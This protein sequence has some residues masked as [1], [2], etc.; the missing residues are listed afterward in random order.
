MKFEAGDRVTVPSFTGTVIDLAS[1]I[2][3]FLSVTAVP[4]N[5]KPEDYTWVL[6]DEDGLVY[7]L[8]D[9]CGDLMTRADPRFWDSLKKEDRWLDNDG[10]VWRYMFVELGGK[11]V[12]RFVTPE[13]LGLRILSKK[14]FLEANPK[15]ELYNREDDD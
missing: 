1:P 7:P 8:F 5:A 13:R 9:P 11:E 4:L 10:K 6:S 15:A 14:K 2:A 3:V 12:M